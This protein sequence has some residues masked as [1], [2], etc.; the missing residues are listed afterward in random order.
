MSLLAIHIEETHR[1]TLKLQRRWVYAKLRASL[2]NEAAELAG[3]RNTR[4][5]TLHICH[6]AGHSRLR[7]CLGKHLQS[8][9]LTRTRSTRYESVT[10]SHLA[11]DVYSTCGRVSYI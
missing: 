2:L 11:N 5:V 3:L 7:E 4:Q 8:D 1:A 10:V 9:G 6:K